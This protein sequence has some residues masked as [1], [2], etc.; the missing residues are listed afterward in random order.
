MKTFLAFLTAASMSSV[1][2]GDELTLRN[3]STFTG[4]VRDEGDR[5]T[6]ETEFGFMT[7]K[8]ID[9][10]S[11]VK[12]RDVVREFAER[13][14]SASSVKELVELA[15]WARDKGLNSRAEDVFRRVLAKEPDHAEARGALGYERIDGRWLQGDELRIARGDVKVDGRWLPKS[16]AIK[17]QEQQ[18][19]QRI[20]GDRLE[21]E[22]RVAAQRH[23]LEMAR[24]ALDRERLEIERREQERLQQAV[25]EERPR[26]AEGCREPVIVVVQP[27]APRPPVRVSPPPQR[28]DFSPVPLT[29]PTVI[30]ITPPSPVPITRSSQPPAKDDE[31]KKR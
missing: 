18:A 26:F 23:E 19:L 25:P 4:A 24:L 8:K 15:A 11:V 27:P 12:G 21:L 22:A 2:F 1:A 14:Q 20:E 28:G 9:V 5:V 13:S 10:R 3:G 6:I 29:P 7:F 17:V 30:P 16:V 31:D